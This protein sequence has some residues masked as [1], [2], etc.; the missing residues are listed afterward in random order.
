MPAMSSETGGL[1]V[2]NIATGQC[3]ILVDI[4]APQDQASWYDIWAAAVALDGMCA[5]AERAGKSRFLG[6]KFHFILSMQRYLMI[7]RCQSE[8]IGHYWEVRNAVAIDWVVILIS[9]NLHGLLADTG[10]SLRTL[11]GIWVVV[12]YTRL[13][14]GLDHYFGDRRQQHTSYLD[15]RSCYL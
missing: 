1:I 2:E 12:Q 15:R 5:R 9:T 11:Q 14:Q 7:F 6:E 10:A 8:D 3:R 13:N 4:T